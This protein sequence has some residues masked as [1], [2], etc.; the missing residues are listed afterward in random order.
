MK[1]KQVGRIIELIV[2]LDRS[3]EENDSALNVMTDMEAAAGIEIDNLDLLEECL[4]LQNML[5]EGEADYGKP[6]Y[7]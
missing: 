7:S 5:E 2:K 3:C 1:N 6:N 4:E